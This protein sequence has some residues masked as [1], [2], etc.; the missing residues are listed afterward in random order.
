[1][2]DPTPKSANQAKIDAEIE[3]I[4]NMSER[5]LEEHLLLM[6]AEC[7]ATSMFEAEAAEDRR[8]ER[9]RSREALEQAHTAIGEMSTEALNEQLRAL[10]DPD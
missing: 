4:Q 8:N 2:D 5:E 9:R 1:M 6:S 10:T 3:R 7:Y